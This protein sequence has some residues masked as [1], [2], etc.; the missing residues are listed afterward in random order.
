MKYLSAYAL[1]WL[2]GKSNPSVK[3]LETIISAAG[4]SFDKARA[5]TLIES[6]EERDLTQVI[7]SGL[8]KL[9]TS[10]GPVVASSAQSTSANV[11]VVETKKEE[12][13]DDKKD[14]DADFDGALDMF[15]DD[16]Y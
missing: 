9:Q 16:D 15:G 6:L 2:S 14:E 3:D 4:G 12:K 11:E 1:A 7:R 8:T 5:E 10:G 13:K